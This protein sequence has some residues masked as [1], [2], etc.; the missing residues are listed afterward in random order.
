ME[1]ITPA[2]VISISA[3]LITFLTFRRDKYKIVV[4]LDL[5]T[6]KEI[7][8]GKLMAEPVIITVTN[9]G[10]RSVFITSVGLCFDEDENIDDLLSTNGY[11]EGTTLEEGGKPITL[12]IRKE[13]IPKL[14]GNWKKV[15]ATASDGSRT[16]YISNKV[17]RKF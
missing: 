7:V 11:K 6:G 2:L 9:V 15:Y 14:N 10:R 16:Y 13:N 12:I 4:T 1:W 8:N 17:K 3:L 5:E